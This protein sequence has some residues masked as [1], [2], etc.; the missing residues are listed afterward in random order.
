M[1]TYGE[2]PAVAV[3]AHN[4][5][6]IVINAAI[7]LISIPL[8][9]VN[10]GKLILVNAAQLDNFIIPF[11]V[12]NSS[13]TID[14]SNVAVSNVISPPTLVNDDDILT[15]FNVAAVMVISPSIDVTCQLLPPNVVVDAFKLTT[16]KLP[17]NYYNY[18][19]RTC[20]KQ[21]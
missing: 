1:L 7:V 2:V 20:T 9:V 16:L 12:T 10:N 11:T 3:L 8:I 18:Y 21:M 6:S 19:M 4:G 14:V 15:V 5:I 13:N 17:P